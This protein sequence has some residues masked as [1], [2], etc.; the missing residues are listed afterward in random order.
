MSIGPNQSASLPLRYK[1]RKAP[2]T[3]IPP[4]TPFLN[5]STTTADALARP[6]I[7]SN[8]LM[9]ILGFLT[10][11]GPFSVDMY[12][13][14]FPAIAASLGTDVGQVQLTLAAYFFG[15]S[16]GQILYGPAIDRYGRR[17]PMLIGI[18]VYVCASA[19]LVFAPNIETFI[20]LRF[21][22]AL[23]ACGGMVVAR[24]MIRDLFGPREAA[25]AM[26]TMMAVVSLGPIVAPVLGSVMLNW[27]TWHAIFVFLT[28]YG[29]TLFLVAERKIPETLPPSKRH[30]DNPLQVL[31]N[32]GALLSR[33]RFIVP[34][35][36]GAFGF[37]GV[38]AY[39]TASPFVMM[40]LYGLSQQQFGWLFGTMA[41]GLIIATQ[42]N[43]MLLK[44][45][46]PQ[47]ILTC[48]VGINV[49]LGVVLVIITGT[50][51]LPLFAIVLA[52][53]IATMP[54]I[55]ANTVAIAM[56]ESGA[57]AGTASSIV[58]V[59]QFG[60]ASLLSAMIGLLHDGTAR[61]MTTMMLVC[62]LTAVC[63]LV[64]GKGSTR[65]TSQEAT[66]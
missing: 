56:A 31:R 20:G 61:P 23:G 1:S 54:L 7:N 38:F 15:V 22:Q 34:A 41:C 39:V 4:D 2:S 9:L 37:A 64:Y 42:I 59:L 60:V 40:T 43:R 36:T 49:T 29:L 19:A 46:M 57:Y 12:L 55:G 17:R 5:T 66:A 16:L 28:G 27:T 58:G 6:T 3:F 47:Q 33:R 13:S 53:W 45:M 14:G 50:E 8:R 30:H 35:L 21:I 63:L 26:S 44:R 10:A 18:A 52:V 62:G 65:P 25:A 51:S 32:F 24:A 11:F 48:T